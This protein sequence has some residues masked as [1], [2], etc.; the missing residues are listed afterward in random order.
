M[1]TLKVRKA[2]P[3]CNF[4]ICFSETVESQAVCL[5]QIKTSMDR[6][7]GKLNEV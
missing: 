1:K 6:Y 5:K 4:A 2:N 3:D 7:S